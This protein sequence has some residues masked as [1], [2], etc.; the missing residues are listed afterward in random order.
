M[1]V[2]LSFSFLFRL[3]VLV[4]EFAKDEEEEFLVFCRVRDGVPGLK[5]SAPFHSML[6]GFLS[7]LL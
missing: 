2:S 3:S 7:I 1:V 5:G 4:C 6:P